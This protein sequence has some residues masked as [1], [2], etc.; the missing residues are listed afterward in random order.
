MV[1]RDSHYR[2]QLPAANGRVERNRGTH[3]DWLVK[4]PRLKKTRPYE[5]KDEHLKSEH[6]AGHN[7]RFAHAPGRSSE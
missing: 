6:L 1:G 2:G 5:R 3:Q 4:N 7:R